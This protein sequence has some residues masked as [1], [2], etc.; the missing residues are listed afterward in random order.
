VLEL[1]PE[2]GS[3]VLRFYYGQEGESG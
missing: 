1:P 2:Q 3:K